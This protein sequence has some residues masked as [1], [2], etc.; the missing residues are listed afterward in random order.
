MKELPKI[1]EPQKVENEIYMRWEEG[2]FFNPDN[3]ASDEK[4]C[5]ILPPPNANGELHIGHASGYTVMDIFGRWA[6]MKG[7][8]TLLLPGK[9]HA[10]IQTQVVFEKKLK[11]ELGLSRQ[12]IGREE[13]Y[14]K[15][16]DFCMDRSGYMR[17]Q[18]KK[19]WNQRRL[20]TRKVHARSRCTLKRPANFC[21]NA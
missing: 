5:N 11:A 2:G 12:E 21:E 15:T 9:D 19:D 18:E 4:Y 1:Y 17:S 6:R 3:I 16:Y 14:K 8:K 10:G 20:V 13:F 7:K